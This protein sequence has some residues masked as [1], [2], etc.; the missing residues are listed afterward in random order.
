VITID[1][2]KKIEEFLGKNLRGKPSFVY[3]KGVST[4]SMGMSQI[5]KGILERRHDISLHLNIEEI[6]IYGGDRYRSEKA[7]RLC[8]DYGAS[9]GSKKAPLIVAFDSRG[10]LLKTAN[11]ETLPKP[12]QGA[13][14]A[15]F[16]ELLDMEERGNAGG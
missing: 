7:G 5:V 10:M 4:E 12:Y 13:V 6:D 15:I 3:F 8:R 9:I 14:E 11:F 1:G 2:I 16:E